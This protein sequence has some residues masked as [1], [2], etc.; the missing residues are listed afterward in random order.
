MPPQ[1]VEDDWNGHRL[2]VQSQFAITGVV[3][4]PPVLPSDVTVVADR[5]TLKWLFT[6]MA[7]DG[8]VMSP[9]VFL[10]HPHGIGVSQHSFDFA[11][12]LLRSAL[13]HWDLDTRLEA[14]FA[15]RIAQQYSSS[16]SPHGA[17]F[18]WCCAS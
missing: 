16:C 12:L 6:R 9:P 1:V 11:L 5:V 3:G 7:G 10:C 8:A 4:G 2:G 14:L 15:H 17:A 18:S 13:L